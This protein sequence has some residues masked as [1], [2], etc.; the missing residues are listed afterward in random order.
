M[1]DLATEIICLR[2][3]DMKSLIAYSSMGH[4]ALLIGGLYSTTKWGLERA[5]I[6]MVAHG[7]SRRALFA[8]A[9]IAYEASNSRRLYLSKG[10]LL[11]MPSMALWWFLMRAANMAA[12][13]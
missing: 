5:I 9:N 2:Q 8:L 13:P 1:G 11:I 12:P 6:M 10:I 7:L 4:M 3:Q